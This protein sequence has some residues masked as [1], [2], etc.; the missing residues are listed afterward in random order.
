MSSGYSVLVDLLVMQMSWLKIICCSSS[1]CAAFE[2]CIL[3]EIDS[4]LLMKVPVIASD[5]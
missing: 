2:P 5:H 1:A 4:L 3:L